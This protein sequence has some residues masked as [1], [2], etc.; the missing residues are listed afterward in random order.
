MDGSS[1]SFPGFSLYDSFLKLSNVDISIPEYTGSASVDS[2]ASFIRW[3]SNM[4]SNLQ[5][6]GANITIGEGSLVNTYQ[7]GFGGIYMHSISLTAAN[8]SKVIS[9]GSVLC[10]LSL[11][12]M[13]IQDSNGNSLSNVDIIGGVVKDANGVPRNITT[14]IIL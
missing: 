5:V 12:S 9:I 11:K 13:T 3:D 4:A 1:V 7:N 10:G 8:P 6:S 14:D 2:L